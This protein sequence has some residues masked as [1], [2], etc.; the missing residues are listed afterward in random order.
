MDNAIK[1]NTIFRTSKYSLN[2]Q[3][4]GS[5]ISTVMAYLKLPEERCRPLMDMNPKELTQA[6]HGTGC[7]GQC[8]TK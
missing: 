3:L 8:V 6:Y 2:N 4:S 1:F 5:E 7:L